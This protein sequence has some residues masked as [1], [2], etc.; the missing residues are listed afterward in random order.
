MKQNERKLDWGLGEEKVYDRMDKSFKSWNGI[1]NGYTNI[2]W[3][4]HSQSLIKCQF[5]KGLASRFYQPRKQ[6]DMNQ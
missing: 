3:H 2:L 4:K 5:F 6:L 1:A